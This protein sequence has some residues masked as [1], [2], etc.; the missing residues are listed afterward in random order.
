MNP[1][2]ELYISQ[3]NEVEKLA[4]TLLAGTLT[5]PQSLWEFQFQHVT[6]QIA[7]HE[8]ILLEKSN[9]ES[10]KTQIGEV[11]KVREG[12][13]KQRIQL[14]QNSLKAVEENIEIY[15][16]VLNMSRQL[17]DALAWILFGMN[18]RKIRP[19]TEN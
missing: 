12:D 4:R 2:E 10:L 7:L 6:H 8:K 1:Q 11:A 14:L 15:G 5:T 19:L 17:G 9:K 16:Y 3:M 18:E 13:W